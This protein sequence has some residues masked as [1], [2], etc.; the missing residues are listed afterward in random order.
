VVAVEE[1]F[2]GKLEIELWLYGKMFLV[3]RTGSYFYYGLG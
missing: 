3:I 2:L 1:Q